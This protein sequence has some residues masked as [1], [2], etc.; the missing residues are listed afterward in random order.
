MNKSTEGANN[1][2]SSHEILGQKEPTYNLFNQV[3]IKKVP[4]LMEKCEIKRA[5]DLKKWIGIKKS[6]DIMIRKLKS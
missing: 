3:D 6:K 4:N 1:E 2:P 5:T